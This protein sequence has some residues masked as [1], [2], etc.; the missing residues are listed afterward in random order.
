M[1]D[2]LFTW[3]RNPKREVAQS[4]PTLF[5]RLRTPGAAL[6]VRFCL[7]AEEE[8]DHDESRRPP[9]PP[10]TVAARF[11]DFVSVADAARTAEQLHVCCSVSLLR[12]HPAATFGEAA[13]TSAAHADEPIR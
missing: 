12:P 1:D 13:I 3:A 9:F 11:A 8:V 6:S 7:A 10:V 5:P 4:E 2:A